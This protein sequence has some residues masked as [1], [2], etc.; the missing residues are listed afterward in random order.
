MTADQW[1]RMKELFDNAVDRGP[2][3]RAAFLAGACGGDAALRAE[4]ERLLKAHDEASG[5]IERFAGG[6]RRAPAAATGPPLTGRVIGRYEIGRL[7]APAAWVRSTPPKTSTWDAR[8][9]SKVGIATD[10]DAHAR[11]KR[12]AQHASRLNHPNICTIHEVGIHDDQPFIVMELVE[13]TA[14]LAHHSAGRPALPRTSCVT[15][16]RLPMRWRTRIAAA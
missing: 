13:G 12:E 8:S 9:R 3:D 6:R 2:A 7:W 14:A 10:D 4:L 1:L 11:L 15:G 5:F 16:R